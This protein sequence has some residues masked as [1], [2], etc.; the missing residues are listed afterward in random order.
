MPLQPRLTRVGPDNKFLDTR[1][2]TDKLD[3]MNSPTS[4]N[5]PIFV[6]ILQGLPASGKSTYAKELVAQGF[7][8]V[9]RD[10]LRLMLDLGQWS[11]AN[12]KLVSRIEREVIRSSIRNGH[13]MV[14]DNTHLTSR[15]VKDLV[16]FVQL[17]AQGT[18]RAIV[19]DQVPFNTPYSECCARNAVRQGLARVPDHVMKSM[20]QKAGLLGSDGQPT[21]KPLGSKT[22]VFS[23]LEK[24]V[25][26]LADD[27]ATFA[28]RIPAIV[29]DL[30]G[31]LALFEGRRSPYEPATC[32]EDDVN[33]VVRD[34]C[35]DARARGLA[36]VF[37]SGR[38]DTYRE[39]TLAFLRRAFEGSTVLDGIENRLHMRKAGDSR[40]DAIVKA[41]IYNRDLRPVYEIRYV[42]DDRNQVVDMWRAQGHV[43]LQVANGDF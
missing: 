27:G 34:L 43:C 4:P 17:L 28:E 11:P 32:A 23:K 22:W 1:D 5:P 31:T 9:N 6:K 35:L 15:S 20:G 7:K 38:E 36:V 33:Q 37:C 12:E 29:C 39:G 42:L 16:D 18:D 10:E 14:V 40:K 26:V 2:E 3:T 25:P 8:R 24:E 21:G 41:E 19:V 13:N 30:D